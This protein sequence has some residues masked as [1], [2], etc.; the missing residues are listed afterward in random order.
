M[1]DTTTNEEFQ[2]W[3]DQ[4][5]LAA[6][7]FAKEST[8]ELTANLETEKKQSKTSFFA[9]NTPFDSEISDNE[10]EIEPSWQD[11]YAKSMDLSNL[12]VDWDN[13]ET[14]P[15]A[16]FGAFT[17]TN[18]NPTQQSSTGPDGVGPDGHVRVTKNFSD[19]PE[20]RELD[21]LKRRVEKMEREHHESEAQGGSG[22]LGELENLRD[23]INKLSE[24][25][26]KEPEV[27]VT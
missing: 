20:L 24:K 26:N 8:S 3:Q 17:P 22:I 12:I 15:K 14:K 23:R 2:K 25:I 10:P 27:D 19:S 7:Q 5:D 1:R 9:P 11:I 4:W 21:E 16:N 18:T 13:G 6:K